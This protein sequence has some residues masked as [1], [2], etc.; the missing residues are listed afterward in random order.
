MFDDEVSTTP[1]GASILCYRLIHRI[2]K[3]KPAFGGPF[4]CLSPSLDFRV[5]RQTPG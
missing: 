3:R 4:F 5:F 2:A 1:C